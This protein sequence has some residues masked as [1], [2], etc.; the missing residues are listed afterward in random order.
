MSDCCSSNTDM[1]SIADKKKCPIN[2]QIY[3]S[4]SVQT[5]IH[6]VAKPWKLETE[7]K[8]F[9]FCDDSDCNVVYFTSDNSVILQ[10][11]L[12]TEIGIKDNSDDALICYCFGITRKEARSPKIK[13]Y[14]VEQ[15]RKKLC[16]CET[17][18]PSGK[19]CLKDFPKSL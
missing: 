4:V 15:T 3:R 7:N 8:K 5:V 9:Y 19:C 17:S 13:K 11:Q 12:R 14:V 16:S 10:D 2:K 6:H 18:N 1:S